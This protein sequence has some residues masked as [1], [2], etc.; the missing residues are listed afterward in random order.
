M[1]AA[2]S[3]VFSSHPSP[4]PFDL[5]MDVRVENGHHRG[6][7]G[8]VVSCIWDTAGSTWTYH[9]RAADQT[10]GPFDGRDLR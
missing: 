10:F 7:F 8:R 3:V 4:P 2:Q 5:S 6:V 9:I 1:D